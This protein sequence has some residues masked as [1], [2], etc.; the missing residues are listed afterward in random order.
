MLTSIL[1]ETDEALSRFASPFVDILSISIAQQGALGEASL[2]VV[3]VPISA[4]GGVVAVIATRS[5]NTCMWPVRNTDKLILPLTHFTFHW[6]TQRYF[7]YAVLK[8][9]TYAS[10]VKFWEFVCENRSYGRTAPQERFAKA[11]TL[12]MAE[13]SSSSVWIL[14]RKYRFWSNLSYKLMMYL[15]QIWPDVD[16]F[17]LSKNRLS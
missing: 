4:R 6:I 8:I 14:I 10:F 7:N 1:V 2:G 17:N 5:W 12:V 11:A 13:A 9:Q 15:S 3:V 16:G